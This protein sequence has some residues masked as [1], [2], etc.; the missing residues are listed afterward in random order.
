M[1]NVCAAC[2]PEIQVL[3]EGWKGEENTAKEVVL[4]FSTFPLAERLAQIMRCPS[5]VLCKE[6]GGREEG[7]QVSKPF[8]GS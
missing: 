6:Q 4:L 3:T 2:T 8:S 1:F 5:V 7:S